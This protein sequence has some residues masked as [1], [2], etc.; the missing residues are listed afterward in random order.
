MVFELAKQ[1]PGPGLVV[2]ESGSTGP[3]VRLNLI[4][5]SGRRR[6]ERTWKCWGAPYPDGV[7]AAGRGRWVR[8]G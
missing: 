5:P 7:V 3:L 4:Y 2:S 8:A 6:R 1:D